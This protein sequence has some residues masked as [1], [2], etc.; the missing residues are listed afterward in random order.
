MNLN[1]EGSLAERFFKFRTDVFGEEEKATSLFNDITV[2]IPSD[3]AE[4]YI[5]SSFLETLDENKTDQLLAINVDN[6][7]EYLT[8]TAQTYW[9]RI[10]NKDSNN[11]CTMYFVIFRCDTTVTESQ[12]GEECLTI[13]NE[14]LSYSFERFKYLSYFKTMPG[15]ATGLNSTTATVYLAICLSRLCEK[16]SVI[17]C[18]IYDVFSTISD[19]TNPSEAQTYYFTREAEELAVTGLPLEQVQPGDTS[20]IKYFWGYLNAYGGKNTSVVFQSV[21]STENNTPV[22]S[23][24]IILGKWFEETNATGGFVGNK[25]DHIRLTGEGVHPSGVRSD[26]DTSIYLNL[27]KKYYE[28]LDAKNVGYFISIASNTGND[29]E[30]IS[31]KSLDGVPVTARMISRWV[32]FEASQDTAKYVSSL[33]TLTK[34]V[35][36][37]ETAYNNI[38]NILVS[39][40]QLFTG[41]VQNISLDFPPYTEA[42]QGNT[43]KGHGVWKAY[44]IG[45]LEGCDISGSV[46]F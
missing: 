3:Q 45:D 44:Y 29:A 16:H 36:A 18:M 10:F 35:L 15:L 43:F 11:F 21:D 46:A 4:T 40:L 22:S 41:R 39:K 9:G 2:Y 28:N 26:V 27:D 12:N 32:D 13:L 8:E 42:K 6:Y 20:P 37:D 34:P 23:W 19:A 25:L 17:S 31:S 30:V 5:K 38:I 33:T 7:K 14:Q 1:Y 24:S